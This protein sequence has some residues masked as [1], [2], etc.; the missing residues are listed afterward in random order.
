MGDDPLSGMMKS[1]KLTI[2]T[3]GHPMPVSHAVAE[4]SS[5]KQDE[6]LSITSLLDMLGKLTDP[7]KRRGKRHKLVFILACAVIA[8]LAGA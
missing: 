6:D 8:V 3:E 5:T 4:E 1:R 7:R 2:Q